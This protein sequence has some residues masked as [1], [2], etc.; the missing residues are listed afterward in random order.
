VQILAWSAAAL[1]LILDVWL[2]VLSIGE[3]L[4]DAGPQR[5]WLEL[6]LL[7]VA[8]ALLISADVDH[9]PAGLAKLASKVRARTSRSTQ[10]VATNLPSPLYQKILV[11]LDHTERDREAIA[12]ATAMAKQH[13]AT[14]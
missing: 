13:N 6:L 2:V 10:A 12:H 1:I 8:I 3:W 5:V 4:K 7:P 11:P 9:I 14:L